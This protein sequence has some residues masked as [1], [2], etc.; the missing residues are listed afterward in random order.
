MLSHQ[1]SYKADL[2]FL[3]V[4]DLRK[5]RQGLQGYL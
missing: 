5:G 1:V 4:A 3:F 2:V